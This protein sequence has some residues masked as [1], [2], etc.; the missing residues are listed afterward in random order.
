MRLIIYIL[1]YYTSIIII[2]LYVDSDYFIITKDNGLL[3]RMFFL[4]ITT[5]ILFGISCKSS[6]K[7]YFLGFFIGLASYLFIL[8]TYIIINLLNNGDNPSWIKYTS[9]LSDCLLV[10][11]INILILK[12]T[13]LV[14]RTSPDPINL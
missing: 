10:A 12:M 8:F 9:M 4:S 6:Y 14:K 13:L 2:N 3:T 7:N 1:F 5:S 11:T